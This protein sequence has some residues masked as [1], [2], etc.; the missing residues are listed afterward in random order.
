MPEPLFIYLF[1]FAHGAARR[2]VCWVKMLKTRLHTFFLPR[3]RVS[4]RHRT[5]V[6]IHPDPMKTF[7]HIHPAFAR[8][9]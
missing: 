9:Q 5:R 3:I 8:G 7:L 1:I 2:R 6:V 4:S